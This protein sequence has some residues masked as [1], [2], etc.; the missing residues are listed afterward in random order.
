[1]KELNNILV[2]E[3]LSKNY[4]TVVA[5]KGVNFNVRKGEIFALLGPDGAGKTTFM[6]LCTGLLKPTSGDIKIFGFSIVAKLD[7][8]NRHIGYMPQN[9][10]LYED[11]TVIE[12]MAFFA[13]LFQ[14]PKEKEMQI[15]DFYL[16]L[17]QLL[18]HKDKL[19]GHLSGG[20]KQK[21]SLA[22]CLLHEPEVIFLDEPTTGVDPVAR[23]EFWEHLKFLQKRGITII[24]TTPYMD[25]AEKCDR[26]ALLH[27][28]KV[29]L[30]G[31]L[32]KILNEIP[33]KAYRIGGDN[34]FL[35]K[36]ELLSQQ[37]IK[38]AVIYGSFIHVFTDTPER[39]FVY[40]KEKNLFFEAIN[41][42]I[43]DVFI[44][45]VAKADSESKVN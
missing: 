2:V 28:G 34:V 10:S 7:E 40:C 43:E 16:N 21:L 4:D 22:C 29:L 12:N 36:K 41:P 18:S 44:Y 32:E 8:A 24:I 3:G 9:F 45:L 15:I 13:S 19:A 20:M 25:E 38:D 30:E 35:L 23:K 42:S 1:M 27:E 26:L 31:S 39:L 11:L 17:T 33:Y 14:L 5:L 37:Y 6:R